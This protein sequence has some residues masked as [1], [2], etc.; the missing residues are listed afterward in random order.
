VDRD[1]APKGCRSRVILIFVDGV[2]NEIRLIQI[3]KL[4]LCDRALE[5]IAHRS[6]HLIGLPRDG[7][8]LESPPFRAVRRMNDGDQ[9]GERQ[10]PGGNTGVEA[11]L[12]RRDSRDTAFHAQLPPAG[13]GKIGMRSDDFA[14][15]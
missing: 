4:Q 2:L 7:S 13:A 15:F 12:S 10:E 5:F 8:W 14:F 6:H 9:A 3:V 1:S 11:G